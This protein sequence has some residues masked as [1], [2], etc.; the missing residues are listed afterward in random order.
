MLVDRF[1]RHIEYLRLSVTDRCNLSCL[2]CSPRDIRWE[3]RGEILSYEE[4]TTLIRIFH[5][6]GV[7]RVRLTGGEPLLRRDFVH[8][9]EG[10]SGLEV[11]LDLSLTTN[12]LLLAGLAGEL[13]RAGLSRVNISLDTLDREKYQRITGKDGLH[14]VLEGIDAALESGLEP[15]KV[16]VVLVRGLNDDE[17]DSFVDLAGSKRLTVRFIEFMPT[18]LA[19]WDQAKLIPSSAVVERLKDKY[20][21]S[22]NDSHSGGGPSVEYTSPCIKGK[23][24]FV[25]SVTEPSC[26]ACNRLRVTAL[27]KLRPCLFSEIELDLKAALRGGNPEEDLKSVILEGVR[28]KP[29]GNSSKSVPEQTSRPMAQIGG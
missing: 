29:A 28:K 26:P 27:G 1:G 15:V 4:M 7:R 5:S 20:G 18:G 25:S 12:G 10:I 17:I 19:Q 21:L 9:V 23:I 13:R 6:L 2:Y 14:S 16:N 24:G 22:L 8:F 11:P 3:R